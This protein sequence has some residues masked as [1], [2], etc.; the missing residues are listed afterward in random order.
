MWLP[1]TTN[2]P[3]IRQ[4]DRQQRFNHENCGGRYEKFSQNRLFWEN[5]ILQIVLT[6]DAIYALKRKFIF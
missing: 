1:P 3:G 5:Q 6:V 2:E 4:C